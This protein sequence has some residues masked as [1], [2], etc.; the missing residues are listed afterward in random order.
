MVWAIADWVG[1]SGVILAGLASKSAG[2]TPQ[3]ATIKSIISG[4][5]QL[6]PCSYF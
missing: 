4:D 1:D 3:M 6:S 2:S 5:G